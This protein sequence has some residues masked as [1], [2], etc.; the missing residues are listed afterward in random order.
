LRV[1][2][3]IRAR[4]WI[5]EAIQNYNST[6]EKTVE[7]EIRKFVGRLQRDIEQ[8][9]RSYNLFLAVN[10]D[11]P[12]IKAKAICI[13]QKHPKTRKQKRSLIKHKLELAQLIKEQRKDAEDRH[14]RFE[15]A[16][17]K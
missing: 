1:D 6:P 14:I 10:S 12:E 7:H 9:N 2:A 13:L 8:L 16:I 11:N 17:S 5:L 4:Q 3:K 15:H